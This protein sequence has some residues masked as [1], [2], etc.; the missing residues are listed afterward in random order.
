MFKKN[1]INAS[2][3]L[4]RVLHLGTKIKSNECLNIGT[5]RVNDMLD[6]TGKHAILGLG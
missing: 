5:E 2:S 1:K 6:G 4:K 3:N